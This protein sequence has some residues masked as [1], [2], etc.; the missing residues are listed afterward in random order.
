MVERLNDENKIYFDKLYEK[1]TKE[2]VFADLEFIER[3]KQV[4]LYKEGKKYVAFIVCAIRKDPV[5]GCG[6]A[7][8]GYIEAL[9]VQRKYRDEGKEFIL[10]NEFEKWAKEHNCYE[11]AGDISVKNKKSLEFYEQSGFDQIGVN[12][13][14]R[15]RVKSVGI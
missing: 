8:V 3:D 5:I 6:S 9:F 12:I 4:F 2:E 13:H 1:A 14:F 10:I 7:N 11:L 15:K